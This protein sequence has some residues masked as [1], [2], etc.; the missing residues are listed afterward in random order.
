MTL[1]LGLL[2]PAG[3]GKSTVAEYLCK[4]YGA[5]R[6]SFASPL[7]EMAR[8]IWE[9]S[10]DQLFGT[11]A[12]KEAVDPRW[13]MSP[14]TALQKLGTDACRSILGPDIWVD[15][16][17]RMIADIA[18]RVAVIDDVRFIN[19]ATKIRAAGGIIWRLECPNRVSSAGTVHPSEV[20][21]A[22]APFDR[23]IIAQTSPGAVQLIA[24]AAHAARLTPALLDIE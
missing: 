5:R 21:W 15:A 14:R 20:E 17:L 16:T 1:I 10:D 6:F 11:Q 8:R 12:Q 13:N 4:T 9:F 3:A 23:K 24:E 2:G 18:P 22:H 7:K 19:E